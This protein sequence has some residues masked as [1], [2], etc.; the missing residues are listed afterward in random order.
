MYRESNTRLKE[1]NLS[2]TV[3]FGGNSNMVWGSFAGNIAIVSETLNSL[4]Y[5]DPLTTNLKKS[6]GIMNLSE[7]TFQQDNAPCHKSKVT[8]TYFNEKSIKL[9][10]W[11]PQSPDLNLIENVLGYME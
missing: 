9:M 6:L 8:M 11:P 3:K 2:P 1:K 7:Y 10:E 4:A 5:I